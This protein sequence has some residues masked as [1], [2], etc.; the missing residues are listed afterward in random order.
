MPHRAAPR[1]IICGA[2]ITGLTT[3][4]ALTR[5][6]ADVIVLEAA[7]AVGG[8][9][10]TTPRDGF[11]CERG[12]NSCTLTPAL[13]TLIAELGL[14]DT[15]REAAPQARRRY[16]VRRGVPR[17]VPTTPVDMLRSPLLS[18][19]GKLRVLAE[20]FVAARRD[21]SDESIAGFVARRLGGE[22]LTWAI[23]PFVSGVYAGDPAQ[24]SV[25]HAFPTLA[26]L[27]R[28][29]G[30]L[31]RGMIAR[32]RAARASGA[33][34]ER[35][36]MIS[37]IDGLG[38]L[39]AAIARELPAD[40]LH[41]RTRVTAVARAGSGWNVAADHDGTPVSFDADVVI[42]TLP[43]HALQQMTLPP[44]CA[45]LQA[46]LGAV[47]YPAVAALALG[48]RRRDVAHPLDGFG[49]LV[50]SVEGRTT[51][52]VLFSSTLFEGRAPADHV[53]LTCFIGGTRMPAMGV[54]STDDALAAVLP[55]LR[56]LLG[57]TGAPVLVQHTRWPRSIPQFD[58]G[59]DRVLEAADRV[60]AELPGVLLDGQF[61]RGV[62][63][64]DCV[65]AGQTIADRAMASWQSTTADHPTPRAPADQLAAAAVA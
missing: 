15:V 33:A 62:S 47:R 41:L 19:A 12:P 59:H 50:P 13:R 2:G 6:G 53:L 56:D 7:D 65:A 38:A 45:S 30:S 9:M 22:V 31:I 32:S 23:D 57:V 49:C 11:L 5:A 4:R 28:E 43:L 64:G 51:L 44:S 63:V 42:L 55:E 17:A 16:I 3:A 58:V 26:T 20:P 34:R 14:R 61:R 48:F 10:Q 52:G 36:T 46:Q 35:H 27:E 8:V 1:V 40:R 18:L 54:A 25:R 39:P 29:H 24:L 60:E 21:T 37:F